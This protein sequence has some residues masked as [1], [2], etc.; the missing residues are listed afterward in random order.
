MTK[1]GDVWIYSD[2]FFGE[3]IAIQESP[4]AGTVVAVRQSEGPYVYTLERFNEIF[5]EGPYMRKVSSD[6]S[7]PARTPA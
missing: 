3:V 2:T 5:V 7:S 4:I 1:P 6:P